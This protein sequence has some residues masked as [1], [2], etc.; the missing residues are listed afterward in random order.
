MGFF[1]R[2]SPI[3]AV[4]DLRRF[5]ATR[6][7]YELGFLALAMAITSG[8]I[9]L[10]VRDSEVEVPYVPHIV[11]VQQWRADRTDAQIKAQQVIDQA[12][13][14]QEEAVIAAERA[15]TQAEFKRLDDKL[16]RMGL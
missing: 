13:R 10:F 8:L 5:L 2:F 1:R 3:A 16:N 9:F 6:E 4:N 12:K 11:Y 14:E 7:P 15:K